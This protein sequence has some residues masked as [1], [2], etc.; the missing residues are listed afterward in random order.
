MSFYTVRVTEGRIW[1]LPKSQCKRFR[2]SRR[3]KLNKSN[4]L[5]HERINLR[6]CTK[7]SA[8]SLNYSRSISVSIIR[9]RLRFTS[10]IDRELINIYN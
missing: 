2:M 1:I 9:D 5:A 6:L 8:L 3:K 10:Q 4:T 7:W